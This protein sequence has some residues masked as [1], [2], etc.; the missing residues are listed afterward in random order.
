MNT[1]TSKKPV[2]DMNGKPYNRGLLMVT[3][4]IGLFGTFLAG[5]MLATA[6]PTLMNEFNI[7]AST[8]QWLSTGFMLVTGIMIPITAWMMNRFSSKLLYIIGM[9]LFFIGNAI[10]F[11]ASD[12]A[13]L[14]IGRIVSALGGGILTPLGQSIAM[15]IYPPEKRGTIMGMVGLAIGV[16]PAVGPTLSGWI[17]DSLNWRMIFGI[18]LPF[19]GLDLLL[20]FFYMK[21][22]LPTKKLKLDVLSAILSIIGFGSLLYGTSEAG[23]YG[24]TSPLVIWSII[25][26]LIFIFLFGWRQIKLETP[27]LDIRLL[28]NWHF[29]LASLLG[30]IARIALVGVELVLPL[31]IQIVRGE[32]AFHSGLMLLPGAL[33]MGLMSPIAGM[34]FDRL[35]ARTL[36][37]A[38]LT[39]LTLGTLNFTT[40]TTSTP[41]IEII[42][43]YAVRVMGITLVL[44]PSTTAGLNA[45]P[46]NKMNDG[47]AINNTLRQTL[48]AIG[49]AIFTTVYSNIQNAQ[50]PSKHLLH[51]APLQYKHEAIIAALNG[52][53]AAFF[54]AVIFG[55]IGLILAFSLKKNA[56]LVKKDVNSKNM[57]EA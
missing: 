39:L 31:Y 57:K 47:T 44:M 22:V 45:L 17:I 23:N 36:S 4:I 48:G 37:I 54:T 50:M 14:L 33:L 34:L 35:G 10:C 30:S 12:F 21:K 7:K 9:G 55:V 16:A 38:G 42:V 32:S 28:K 51:V 56:G 52:Y 46:L 26:G 24:W 40:L 29:S 18:T 6:Y 53:H 8:V 3:I 20:S 43:L 13:M 1:S 49:T 19:I 2:L 5:T 27:F 15:S 41:I 11:L 25:I